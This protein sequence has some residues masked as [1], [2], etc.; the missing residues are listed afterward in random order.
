MKLNLASVSFFT[1]TRM[2]FTFLLSLI[3]LSPPDIFLVYF[4]PFS[5]RL[6]SFSQ[7]CWW[8]FTELNYWSSQTNNCILLAWDLSRAG[9]KYEF[10]SS[11]FFLFIRQFSLIFFPEKSFTNEPMPLLTF[12]L[13][14][15]S[16]TTF[17]LSLFMVFFSSFRFYWNHVYGWEKALKFNLPLS[18]LLGY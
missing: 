17:C 12:N 3:F 6:L 18:P 7:T 10:I 9:R 4:S 13:I 15:S 14:I 11:Y 1:H 16:R 5:L 2:I 8:I